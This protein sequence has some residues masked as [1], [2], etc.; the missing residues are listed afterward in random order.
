[1]YIHAHT[2][3]RTPAR[4]HTPAHPHAPAHPHPHAHPCTHA[5]ARMH[6]PMH[7]RMHAPTHSHAPA[8]PY[9]PA[10]LR[11]RL[12]ACLH[13]CTRMH[14]RHA[15]ARCTHAPCMRDVITTSTIAL[16]RIRTACI[17]FLACSP[18]QCGTTCEK[19]LVGAVIHCDQFRLSK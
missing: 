8:H 17:P 1:M 2:C 3:A 16:E 11:T 19:R 4:A 14:S 5:P 13:T 10:R 12:R 15:P 6:A 18:Y 9:A 7:T